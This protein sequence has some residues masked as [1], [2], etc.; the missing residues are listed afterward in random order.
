MRNLKS[1]QSR[2]ANVER[3]LAVGKTIGNITLVTWEEFLHLRWAT[4][5]E[6]FR[7]EAMQPGQSSS[8]MQSV[9]TSPTPRRVIAILAHRQLDREARARGLRENQKV[10]LGAKPKTETPPSS[11][12]LQLH[13]KHS[14][15][16]R[17]PPSAAAD[18]E[19]GTSPGFPKQNRKPKRPMRPL[20]QRLTDPGALLRQPKT[21]SV[22][23]RN[24]TDGKK[25]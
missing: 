8:A 19:A 17:R 14:G 16:L 18:S 10:P 2:L 3:R 24:S 20:R 11:P 1:I 21:G 22:V 13:G 6:R 15:R 9:M 25:E 5:P 12:R 7:R 4:D 23:K